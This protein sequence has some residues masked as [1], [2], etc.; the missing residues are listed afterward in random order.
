MAVHNF[1]TRLAKKYGVA[2]AVML[3]NLSYWQNQNEANQRNF[4]EWCFWTYN[5]VSA[6]AEIFEYLSEKQIQRII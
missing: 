3:W 5:S 2:E 1:E 4:H 6:F